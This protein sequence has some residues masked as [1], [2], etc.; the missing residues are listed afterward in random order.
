MAA[1]LS[2]PSAPEWETR[3]GGV[4]EFNVS[5]RSGPHG[6]RCV[7]LV[8]GAHRQRG[9]GEVLVLRCARGRLR[10][11]DCE[12]SHVGRTQATVCRSHRTR[13]V[14]PKP[15]GRVALWTTGIVRFLAIFGSGVARERELNAKSPEF[16]VVCSGQLG[17]GVRKEKI[18]LMRK[19]RK[20]R[21][22]EQCLTVV[23]GQGRESVLE[24]RRKTRKRTSTMCLVRAVRRRTKASSPVSLSF[25]FPGRSEIPVGLL[26]Y[27]SCPLFSPHY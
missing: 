3:W 22:K 13:P 9:D 1:K 6:S 24:R 18:S 16:V 7:W 15:R 20:E 23:I 19:V 11:H 10:A 5:S 2:T 4:T 14:D 27:L 12:M 17:L 8:L 21:R 26:F 25:N